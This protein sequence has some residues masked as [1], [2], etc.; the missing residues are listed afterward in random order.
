MG[1][2]HSFSTAIAELIGLKDAIILQH[3]FYW[4]QAN[5][6]NESMFI[7]GKV[8]TYQ[9]R[10]NIAKIF[11]YLTQSEIKG[12]IDRLI[13]K[14]YLAS[15]NYNK[16]KLDQTK[17]YALTESALALYDN[18]IDKKSNDYRKPQMQNGKQ[19]TNIENSQ[20]IQEVE[21][22][23]VEYNNENKNNE[24]FEEF[25]KLFGGSKR[26]LDTEYKNFKDKHKDWQE[27]LPLL[28]PTLKKEIAHRD[29]LAYKKEFVPNWANLQTWINKRRW[30]YEYDVDN[31]TTTNPEPKEE[32]MIINGI[33]YK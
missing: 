15:G 20:P 27:C 24:I 29:R 16:Y 18:A 12:A 23:K 17:W 3:F 5:K 7:D 4:H 9:S 32:K 33:E 30:E 1:N 31:T 22:N 21:Y 2:S 26:G 25:R 10:A 14:G 11:G 6:T 8:W 28:L 19:P 13:E